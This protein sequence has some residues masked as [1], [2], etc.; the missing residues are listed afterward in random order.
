MTFNFGNDQHTHFTY[1]KILMLVKVLHS[2]D[3][4]SRPEM[5]IKPWVALSTIWVLKHGLEHQWDLNHITSNYK[6]RALSSVLIWFKGLH[7][8]SSIIGKLTDCFPFPMKFNHKNLLTLLTISGHEFMD[9]KLDV[10]N[11][12]MNYI[13]YCRVPFSKTVTANIIFNT[14]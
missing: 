1:Q 5:L 2:L 10:N 8:F 7:K 4:I 6:I 9:V 11:C 3:L 13:S 12:Q 14:K